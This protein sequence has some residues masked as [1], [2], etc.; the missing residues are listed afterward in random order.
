MGRIHAFFVKVAM[1]MTR[2]KFVWPGYSDNKG[3]YLSGNADVMITCH[4][5]I[6]KLFQNNF[7]DTIQISEEINKKI[8]TILNY[9]PC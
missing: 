6:I 2:N 3:M 8:L 1:K 4:S 7:H 9:F 5:M